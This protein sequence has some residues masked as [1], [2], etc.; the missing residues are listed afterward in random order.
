MSFIYMDILYIYIYIYKI[1]HKDNK[2][3]T[4][5]LHLW[6]WQ[7]RRNEAILWKSQTTKEETGSLNSPIKVK[8]R[9]KVKVTQLGLTLCNPWTIYIPW[10]SPG[11]NTGVGKPFSSP[12]DLP[13]PG[14]EPRSPTLQVD[15]LPAQPPGKSYNY[16]INTNWIYNLKEAKKNP[17]PNDFT[18]EFYQN[19]TF[20]ECFTQFHPE[21]DERAILVNLCYEATIILTPKSGKRQHTYTDTHKNYWPV[22]PVNLDEKIFNK[23]YQSKPKV[24]KK[25]NVSWSSRILKVKLI[26]YFKIK[27][28]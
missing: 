22:S 27:I 3:T 25:N 24:N 9:K 14:N 17:D 11:Q 15:S 26:Q 12:G 4:Y 8:E 2:K 20:T 1:H 21:K 13:N 5:N 16:Y 10:N 28:F 23:F 19:F 18:G 6:L 7:L